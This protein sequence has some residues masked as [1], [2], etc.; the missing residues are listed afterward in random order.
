MSHLAKIEIEI[1]DLAA[2]K[3]ACKRLGMEFMEGQR[4]YR[5]FGRWMGDSP[6]PEGMTQNDLGKCDHAIRSDK[7]SYEV[8]VVKREKGYGLVWDYWHSGG[9]AGVIGKTGGLLKQAYS[10]ERGKA[11]ALKKGYRVQEIQTDKGL[12]LRIRVS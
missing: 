8:G 4:S 6:M 1:N 7:C 5:W 10:I 3:R 12:Q 9:L 11:E 2:L